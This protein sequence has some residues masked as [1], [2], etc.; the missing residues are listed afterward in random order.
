MY[1]SGSNNF[2]EMMLDAKY[3]SNPAQTTNPTKTNRMERSNRAT[4]GIYTADDNRVGAIR[5]GFYGSADRETGRR[6][7][8][9][10]R[11]T[12]TR[13]GALGKPRLPTRSGPMD[14]EVGFSG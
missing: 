4:Q 13:F 12:V 1:E 11:S 2:S 14:A 8:T 5:A 7:N 10:S 3:I 9:K 6:G